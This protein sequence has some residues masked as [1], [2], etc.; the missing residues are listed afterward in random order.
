MKEYQMF[1]LIFLVFLPLSTTSEC[2]PGTLRC[3]N[4]GDPS[5]SRAL[6][7]DPSLDY[8][9]FEQ[10][11]IQ[12]K[13]PNCL[14][15]LN[16]NECKVCRFGKFK[17]LS[18]FQ[19][20]I[21]RMTGNV[22]KYPVKRLQKFSIAIFTIRLTLV[23]RAISTLTQETEFADLRLNKL[24]VAHWWMIKRLAKFAI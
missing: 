2:G 6:I 14:L 19:R 1:L 7:C 17:F 22:L 18:N 4:P 16:E 3:I 15:T 9:L 13:I 12:Q 24:M 8:V 23:W 5:N 10:S 11:C 20:I 21:W